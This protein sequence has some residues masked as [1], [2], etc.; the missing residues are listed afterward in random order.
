MFDE[1][2]HVTLNMSSY[3]ETCFLEDTPDVNLEECT[4]SHTIYCSI[5]CFQILVMSDLHITLS[6]TKQYNSYHELT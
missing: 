6:Q 2:I 1:V 4:S 5:H 3:K